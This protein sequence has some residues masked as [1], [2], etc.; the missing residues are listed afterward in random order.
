M[1]FAVVIVWN[2]WMYMCMGKNSGRIMVQY[3]A[4]LGGWEF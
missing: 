3:S 4:F 1:W 2:G